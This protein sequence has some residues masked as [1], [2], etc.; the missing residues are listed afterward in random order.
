MLSRCEREEGE[1]WRGVK[2]RD[3][4]RDEVGRTKSRLCRWA[5]RRLWVICTVLLSESGVW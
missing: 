4:V 5:V 1:R 3:L 2:L